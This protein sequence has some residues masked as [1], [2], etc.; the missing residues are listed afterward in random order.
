MKELYLCGNE[1]EIEQVLNYVKK[2]DLLDKGKIFL[3][4]LLPELGEDYM[5]ENSIVRARK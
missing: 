2:K 1:K 4:D 3:I 5:R